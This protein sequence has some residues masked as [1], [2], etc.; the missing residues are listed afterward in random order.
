MTDVDL[1]GLLPGKLLKFDGTKWVPSDDAGGIG[2]CPNDSENYVRQFNA[3]VKL[4][5][6]TTIQDI[7]DEQQI[8][9][10]RLTNLE[11]DLNTAENEIDVI[12]LEQ[13]T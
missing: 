2:D 13:T 5:D 9:N 10:D 12:E 11:T 8:Q 1:T 4:D 7:T 6:T 3:W